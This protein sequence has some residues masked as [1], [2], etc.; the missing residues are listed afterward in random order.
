MT[1]NP[2]TWLRHP[3]AAA[4]KGT[5]RSS[6]LRAGR[7]AAD[8]SSAGRPGRTRSKDTPTTHGPW[9]IADDTRRALEKCELF[10]DL[11]REQLASVAALVEEH[12]L[13]PDEL[14]LRE[15]EPA[16][17]LFVVVEGRAVAQLQMERGWL[18]LGLVG[19]GDAA[20]WSSLLDGR[21]YPA[22]V[23]A[24]LPMRVARIESSGLTL[25]MNLEPGIGYPIHK[26]LSAIFHRQYEEALKA[27]KTP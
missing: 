27:L 24:L 14:L 3:A 23:R 9:I 25:L 22:S 26:R 15:D 17:Y 12:S 11:S 7:A 20:G 10:Q 1:M 2:D 13:Q 16:R 21:I 6:K 18:C 5:R 4:A 19:P 8:D